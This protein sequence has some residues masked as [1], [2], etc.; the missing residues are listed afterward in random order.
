MRPG[1][2]RFPSLARHWAILRE[3]W[4][5]Q[6]VADRL[7]PPRSDHEFLPAALE[8]VETPPSPLR[9]L[10]M[11][12]ICGLLVATLL[13]SVFGRVDVVAVATGKVVPAGNVKIIQSFDI[14][15]V[16]AIHV[17]NGQFVRA[18]DLLIELDPTLANAQETQSSQALQSARLVKARNDALLAY[19]DGHPARLVPP[20]GSPADMVATENAF[21][22]SAIGQYEADRSTLLGQR[23][24]K[25]AELRGAEGE[26]AKLRDALPYIEK[27]LAAREDL[28]RR[29][30]YSKLRLL[31]YQQAQAEHRRNIDVQLANAARVRASIV[32]LDAQLASLREN[33][34]K[35]AATDLGT[36]N[37]KVSLAAEDVR[38]AVRMRQFNELR[39]PVDGVVQ[40]LAV[41]TIGGVVQPA[42]PLMVIVPCRSARTESCQ[43]G[44]EVE[45]FVQNRDI[46]FIKIGQRVAVKLEAFNFTQYGL[47]DG[48]VRDISRDAIDRS[49]GTEN[50]NREGGGS[51]GSAG[52]AGAGLTYVA[53]IRLDCRPPPQRSG[54]CARLQPGMAVQAEIKTD[55]RR[56]I[57]Y[58]LSPIGRTVGEAGRER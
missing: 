28:T 57:Q 2:P 46:G 41:N 14:G 23:A 34:R 37:D 8:V 6:N 43:G 35:S 33:F 4:K 40:Q 19:S 11:L 13:W 36:A 42:E 3:S 15:A 21:V 32:T 39:A 45:A 18:G 20:P 30:Y 47:L 9:R 7:A 49:G 27:Q 10:L 52:Q 53:R 51:G 44:V 38:K 17:R 54:L 1:E 31:E 22:S 26:V 29:G 5:A 25:I 48:E 24:E 58:L 16:R 55:R 12:S 50:A 56:I